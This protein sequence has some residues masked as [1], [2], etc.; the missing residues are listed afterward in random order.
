MVGG[1]TTATLPVYQRP[2]SR[3]HRDCRLTPSSLDW[4]LLSA[5]WRRRTQSA[6][7]VH[8][9]LQSRPA[10]NLLTTLGDQR[11]DMF[12]Y[13]KT[14]APSFADDFIGDRYGDLHARSAPCQNH[15]QAARME[16]SCCLTI[17]CARVR[18]GLAP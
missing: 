17:H 15:R 5:I 7:S 18:A 9:A 10:R 12:H 6:D 1:T 14:A 2:E 11:F 3:V 4:P 8:R 13:G 16:Q